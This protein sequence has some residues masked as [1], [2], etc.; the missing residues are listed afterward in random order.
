MTLLIVVF[1]E[2]RAGDRERAGPTLVDQTDKY[3]GLG[4]ESALVFVKG[5]PVIKEFGHTSLT[6]CRVVGGILILLMFG[7]SDTFL[8]L[9][10][11]IFS[12][13]EDVLKKK[14]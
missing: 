13:K 5:V 1:L 7:V 2:G 12:S 4:G 3:S 9:C 14:C 10:R 6:Q 11:G 8:E